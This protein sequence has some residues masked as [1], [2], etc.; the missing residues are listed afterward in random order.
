MV[1][2]SEEVRGRSP[3]IRRVPI[4]GRHGIF[5]KEVRVPPDKCKKLKIKE[6]AV[7]LY[8]AVL[9]SAIVVAVTS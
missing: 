9:I 3:N 8:G 5:M 1:M 4:V 7:F 2:Q 6:C